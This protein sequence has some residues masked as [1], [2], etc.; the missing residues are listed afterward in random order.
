MLSHRHREIMSTRLAV[1]F[2]RPAQGRFSH[3]AHFVCDFALPLYSFLRK[4]GFECTATQAAIVLELLD[5]PFTRFGPLLPLVNNIFPNLIIEYVPRFTQKPMTIYRNRWENN[6]ADLDPFSD[7]LR[8]TLSIKP[9]SHGVVL[10]KRGLDRSKYPGGT[11][12]LSSGADRRTIGQ[13]FEELAGRIGM[14]RPDAISVELEHLTLGDQ[15][16]LFLAAD[17]LIGQHGAAFVHAHWMPA[18]G[19][20]IE[21][22]CSCRPLSPVMVPT[23]A[24]L[25]NH[26]YHTVYYPCIIQGRHLTMDI[27]DASRVTRLIPKGRLQ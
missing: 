24:R 2:P 25:R 10:V 19:T 15:V 16:S 21:L 8:Q 23:I 3:F 27:D 13:G 11:P 22:Q 26:R 4:N 6:A 20:L 12:E 18:G 9:S 7:Y 17:V 1:A 5:N 14:L